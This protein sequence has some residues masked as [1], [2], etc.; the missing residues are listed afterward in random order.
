[1]N[2][3]APLRYN[4]KTFITKKLRKG[5]MKRPKLKNL[6]NKNKNQENSFK[7][8]IQRN[9]GVNLLYETKKQYYKNSDIR[10]VTGNKKF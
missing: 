6:F 9:Y 10:K 7:Y 3:P 1:M 8:T 5:I 4:N 2:E